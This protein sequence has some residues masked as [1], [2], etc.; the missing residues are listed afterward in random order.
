MVEQGLTDTAATA[1]GDIVKQWKQAGHSVLI[2]SKS[3]PIKE[4]LVSSRLDND[5]LQAIQGYF[6]GLVS[7]ETGKN[8]LQT[9]G[10]PQG[11]IVFDSAVLLALGKWLGV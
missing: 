9:I 7:N 8:R 11:F 1:S 3:V 6:T 5:E 2:T 4:L 10:L